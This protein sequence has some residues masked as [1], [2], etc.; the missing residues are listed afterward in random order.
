MDKNI[1]GTPNEA[2]TTPEVDADPSS[3]KS[4]A[5]IVTRAKS[6][7]ESTSVPITEKDRLDTAAGALL[8]MH[9]NMTSS[10]NSS[11]SSSP[12][13][14]SNINESNKESTDLKV[15][16]NLITS[17][18]V[19]SE[20][21][22]VTDESNSIKKSYKNKSASN[23]CATV[24]EMVE[25]SEQTLCMVSASSA[26]KTAATNK[27]DSKKSS[28]ATDAIVTADILDTMEASHVENQS[29]EMSTVKDNKHI[30]LSPQVGTKDPRPLESNVVQATETILQDANQNTE[31]YNTIDTHQNSTSETIIEAE[32]PGVMSLGH[33]SSPPPSSSAS[34]SSISLEKILASSLTTD[35]GSTSRQLMQEGELNI[36]IKETGKVSVGRKD[37]ISSQNRKEDETVTEEDDEENSSGLSS[38]TSNENEWDEEEGNNTSFFAYAPKEIIVERYTGQVDAKYIP[39]T[40]QTTDNVSVL[41][42]EDNEGFSDKA[43]FSISTI[44]HLRTLLYSKKG[45][46]RNLKKDAEQV[47]FRFP[48][49]D[50]LST[51]DR[52]EIKLLGDKWVRDEFGR[53][54]RAWL[55]YYPS[56]HSM[57]HNLHTE[58]FSEL[59][60]ENQDKDHA[61]KVQKHKH[62]QMFCIALHD[63]ITMHDGEPTKLTSNVISALSFRFLN[64]RQKDGTGSYIFYLGTL[65]NVTFDDVVPT[66]GSC[67]DMNCPVATNGLAEFLL[68]ITQCLTR[69]FRQTN[70]MYLAANV[71]TTIADYY[72][73]LKFSC[74]GDWDSV[75][76]E[77]KECGMLETNDLQ[78]IKPMLVKDAMKFQKQKVSSLIIK[79]CN[80]MPRHVRE[81][82]NEAD[83]SFKTKMKAALENHS[84]TPVIK[85]YWTDQ[86]CMDHFNLK[87]DMTKPYEPD[88]EEWKK[89]H[90]QWSGQAQMHFSDIKDEFFKYVK[91]SDRTT[92]KLLPVEELL[93]DSVGIGRTITSNDYK[94]NNEYNVRCQICNQN[95]NVHPL[96]H[97]GV[98]SDV[99]IVIEKHFLQH[100][101]HLLALAS[102][103]EYEQFED[104][105]HMIRPCTGIDDKKIHYKKFLKAVLQEYE[106]DAIEHKK[107]SMYT[108]DVFNVY[109]RQY[110]Q[111]PMLKRYQQRAVR[112]SAKQLGC[113][114]DKIEK[115]KNRSV[116]KKRNPSKLVLSLTTKEVLYELPQDFKD[117]YAEE[118]G[119]KKKVIDQKKE[120]M[121]EVIGMKGVPDKEIPSFSKHKPIQYKKRRQPVTKTTKKQIYRVSDK[122]TD[123]EIKLNWTTLLC[124]NVNTWD[125]SKKPPISWSEINED[126]RK[127][128]YIG[129]SDIEGKSVPFIV[130][131]HMIPTKPG[132]PIFDDDFIADM[133]FNIEYPI[134]KLAKD[135]LAEAVVDAPGYVISGIETSYVKGKKVWRGKYVNGTFTEP[136]DEKWIKRSFKK[137]F[138]WYYDMLKNDES[139]VG[140]VEKIPAGKASNEL[141]CNMS[142]DIVEH[143][144]IPKHYQ[145]S[146]SVQFYFDTKAVCA[147]G[148]MANAMH[149]FG[150]EIA[151][152][153]FF[154]NRLKSVGTIM[155][156][157]PNISSSVTGNLFMTAVILAR[158]K[159]GYNLRML[160]NHEPWKNTQVDH[161]IIK[162]VEIHSANATV[163]HAVCIKNNLVYDGSYRNCLKL[164]KDCISW[165]CDD[166]HFFLKCYSLEPKKNLKRH[167]S[168]ETNMNVDKKRNK[169]HKK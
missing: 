130:S 147:F 88:G 21:G 102:V 73:R 15:N 25:A 94:V 86:K 105:D 56:L 100:Q 51:D 114:E 109:F 43:L 131:K 59:F 110:L 33:E 26:I 70:H 161:G 77:V 36:T 168:S 82:K 32:L 74:C 92:G 145:T 148:N 60:E 155:K 42:H 121:K 10:N 169:K 111:L 122:Y 98:L 17:S 99:L 149:L 11:T 27:E 146:V 120:L 115:R 154:E 13:L 113:I 45:T 48:L 132:G 101:S 54:P 83:N 44:H 124:M 65:Q 125:S 96:T 34:S 106:L 67:R 14:S 2:S 75:P 165:L 126:G 58:F 117:I 61:K 157:Y 128:I 127:I 167:L 103:K 87:V 104:D 108:R 39:K 16:T 158:H 141:T 66:N 150:D 9:Q 93:M 53:N 91:A 107:R 136:Q 112:G 29:I 35:H 160:G 163:T 152:R 156:D 139:K 30:T 55:Y 24:D 7:I 116:T 143:K 23:E 62:T 69:N 153:F 90:T 144:F 28:I 8:R 133:A 166:E 18:N 97:Y 151:A 12:R 5:E 22:S 123:D 57:K 52:A 129:K 81:L 37:K 95:M 68:R 135:R 19:L 134:P 47:G 38:E 41:S 71:S 1:A 162:M 118:R 137:D 49:K 164:S 89:F 78:L 142:S 80:N 31:N 6:P 72:E 63:V 76:L 20:E 85:D 4:H 64:A 79:T 3:N 50:F 159:F 138:K 84:N 140:K 40:F 119:C 46:N